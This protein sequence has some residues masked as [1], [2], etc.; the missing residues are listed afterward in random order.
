MLKIGLP[1][2]VSV[3]QKNNLHFTELVTLQ[4]GSVHLFIQ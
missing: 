4:Y 3:C 2:Q 1:D